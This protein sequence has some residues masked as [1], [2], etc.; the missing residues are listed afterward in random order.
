MDLDF[1]DE[2]EDWL[3]P[4]PTAESETEHDPPPPP[5]PAETRRTLA[6]RTAPPLD[7]EGM[8]AD[9]E[10]WRGWWLSA[11]ALD[12]GRTSGRVPPR[13]AAGAPLMILVAQPEAGDS[14]TLLAGPQG[15]LLDAMLRAMG[16]ARD[17][18]YIA[19]ALPRHMPMADWEEL[20]AAGLGAA[21]VQ[22]V[23]LAA[24]ERLIAFGGNILPLFGN[25]PPLS[26]H[27]SREFNLEGRTIP[28]LV[29]RDLESLERGSWKARFWHDWLAWA[30]PG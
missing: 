29:A 12:G 28:L 11:P 4:P 17:A 24:P 26:A 22:H 7:L 19:S 30:N 14:E 20:A 1:H 18:V 21:L 6:P 2:P 9:L 13:G 10:A 3:A 16:L 8:P 23:K 27:S 15:R 5:P 25:D